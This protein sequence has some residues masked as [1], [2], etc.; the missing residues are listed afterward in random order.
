MHGKRR[1][2]TQMS[3]LRPVAARLPFCP[4]PQLATGGI[5]VVRFLA[6]QGGGV[7][8]SSCAAKG[9]SAPMAVLPPPVV[10]LQSVPS[11]SAELQ[12]PVWLN[13]AITGGRVVGSDCV[14]R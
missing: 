8:I 1:R 2:L 4:Q 12:S 3:P 13:S 11:P 7:K 14:V 9:I 5:D 10:L 6:A